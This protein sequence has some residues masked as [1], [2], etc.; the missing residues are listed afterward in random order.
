MPNM[1]QGWAGH[2]KRDGPYILSRRPTYLLLGNIDV[3]TQPR[4][5]RQQPFIPYLTR[6][7]WE[8]EKDLY[9]TDDLPALY[10]PRSV[11]IAPGQF[12][13]F[14]SLRKEYRMS[15]GEK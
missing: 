12:L 5:P 13:N 1:G 10:E 11:Q 14:Y 9:E 15:L 3:T 8:R 4:D 7:I 2:E 6:A